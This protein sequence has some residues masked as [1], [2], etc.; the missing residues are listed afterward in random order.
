[1]VALELKMM[2][3][4][5][6]L[7]EKIGGIK[8]AVAAAL[9]RKGGEARRDVLRKDVGGKINDAAFV[10]P[11]GVDLDA[12]IDE[13]TYQ[14]QSPLFE[15]KLRPLNHIAPAPFGDEEELGVLMSREKNPPKMIGPFAQVAED[16]IPTIQS[17]K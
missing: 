1:M 12:M 9:L 16:F 13:G 8:T 3:L 11:I 7:R 15:R 2:F 4:Q 14:K 10:F 17:Y 6:C 5:P